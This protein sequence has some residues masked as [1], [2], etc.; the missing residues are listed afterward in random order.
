MLHNRSLHNVTNSLEQFFKHFLNLAS[1]NLEILIIQHL[2]R[3]VP[4]SRVLLFTRKKGYSMK[5]ADHRDMF[6]KTSK[7]VCTSVGLVCP[8]PLSPSSNEVIC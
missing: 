6:K 5:Q 8:D 1:D 7:A 4:R 3:A 2:R